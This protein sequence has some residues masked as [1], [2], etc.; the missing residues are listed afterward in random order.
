MWPLAQQA[1]SRTGVDPRLIFAQSALE[2]G[3]GRSAPNNNYFGI[4]GS[5]SSQTTREFING[6]WVTTKDSFRGYGSMG[7]SVSGW[8]DF[9]TG[10]KRYKPLLNADGLDAQLKALGASG[11]ATDPGYVGKLKS[12]IAGLPGGGGSSGGGSSPMGATSSATSILGAVGGGGDTSN[13]VGETKDVAAKFTANL[14]ASGGNP[15]VAAG[16]T[17]MQMAG[18]SASDIWDKIVEAVKKIFANIIE[19]IG[20][21]LE[22]WISRG[23]VG[24]LGLLLIAGALIIFAAQSGVVEKVATVA[25]KA[26]L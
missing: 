18:E 11:Y 14:A 5:G 19:Q 7:D 24:I 12:I 25:A 15:V 20:K 23:A 17:A 9:I 2:T 16:M 22:P 8:V 3:W 1:G 26:A 10:N 21:A 4:K 6:Q 13:I